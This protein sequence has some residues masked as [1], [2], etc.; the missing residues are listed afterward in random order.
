[1]CYL[2]MYFIIKQTNKSVTF[3]DF[4]FYRNE[5]AYEQKKSHYGYI[6]CTEKFLC[7]YS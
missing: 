3:Q 2:F 4:T 1:M 7:S 6:F 5:M